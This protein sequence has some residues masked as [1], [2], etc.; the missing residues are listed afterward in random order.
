MKAL[1]VLAASSGTEGMI[2]GQTV[3]IQSE[4][5]KISEKEL[6]YLHSLKTGAIIRSSGVIGALMSGACE[7]EIKAVDEYCLKLGIAFQ[8]QDDILDVTS[9]TEELGKPV[10]SDEEQGKVTYVSIK[11]LEQAAKDVET[12]TMEAI[13]TLDSLP[14]ENAFL[15]ELL[16]FLIHRN[17]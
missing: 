15:R 17:K 8:I 5:K 14:Y 9:T 10:G 11:G 16:L 6:L 2:G 12:Y 13:D 4:G 3:D 1:A 7:K